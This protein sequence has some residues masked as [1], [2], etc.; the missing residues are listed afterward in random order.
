MGGIVELNKQGLKH[1]SIKRCNYIDMTRKEITWVEGVTKCNHKTIT[2]SKLT[3]NFKVFKC[4]Q[5]HDRR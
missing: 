1:E 2:C 5:K 3:Q 4:T